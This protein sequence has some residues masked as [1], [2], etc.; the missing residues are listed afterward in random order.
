MT[1]VRT[2]SEEYSSM[3]NPILQFQD[4]MVLPKSNRGESHSP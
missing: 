2:I 3:D 4:T 1:A